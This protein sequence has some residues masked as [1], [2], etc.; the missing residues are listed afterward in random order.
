MSRLAFSVA[1][2]PAHMTLTVWVNGACMGSLT[3]RD[4]ERGVI[5][6]MVDTLAKSGAEDV[7][8]RRETVSA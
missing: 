5:D 8:P 7:T 4:G 6:N 1:K 3:C 2:T